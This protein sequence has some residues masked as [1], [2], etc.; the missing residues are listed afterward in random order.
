M[1]MA[2]IPAAIFFI[3]GREEFIPHSLKQALPQSSWATTKLAE[4]KKRI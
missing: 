3:S 2:A 4:R 1:K